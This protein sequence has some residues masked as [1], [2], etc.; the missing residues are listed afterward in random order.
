MLVNKQGK[1]ARI[2]RY[3][4]VNKGQE[5]CLLTDTGLVF[6]VRNERICRAH[7]KAAGCS[8]TRV[9]REEHEAEVKAAKK[10]LKKKEQNIE[11]QSKIEDHDHAEDN[12]N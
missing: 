4:R 10:A 11:K 9:S 5:S 3:F 12:N 6:A 2:A 7:C 8:Y 1:E